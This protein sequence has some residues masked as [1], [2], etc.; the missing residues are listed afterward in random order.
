MQFN[1]DQTASPDSEASLSVLEPQQLNI[2]IIINNNG[3]VS[4]AQAAAYYVDGEKQASGS[5]GEDHELHQRRA[6]ERA[7]EQTTSDYQST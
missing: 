1:A 4:H 5:S 2:I 6:N 7:N 3:I